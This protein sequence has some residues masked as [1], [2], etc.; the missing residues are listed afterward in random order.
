MISGVPA[1]KSSPTRAPARDQEGAGSTTPGTATSIADSLSTFRDLGRDLAGV[2]AEM[3]AAPARAAGRPRTRRTRTR[4]PADV[5]AWPL[6]AVVLSS[7]LGAL[8]V[9][10]GR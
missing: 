6:A 10:V 2:G 7:A 4:R 9:V 5:I 8:L 3:R 1:E